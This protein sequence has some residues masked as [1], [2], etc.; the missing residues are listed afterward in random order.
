M[1]ISSTALLQQ[2]LQ[3]AHSRVHETVQDL[4]PEQLVWRPQ[5]TANSAAFFL[6]H[7]ARTCDFN[8]HSRLLSVPEIWFREN[9]E[10]RIPIDAEGQGTR[11]MGTGTGFTDQQVGAMPALPVGEHSAYLDS[12]AN[13]LDS[14]LAMLPSEQL[15]EEREHV[16]FGKTQVSAV[17]LQMLGHA[18]MAYGRDQLR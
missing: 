5:A 4:T 18:H 8:L 10:S 12:V 2:A 13:A 15:S 14:W 7:V 11:G 6:W 1:S 17:L 16:G 9:W 3:I